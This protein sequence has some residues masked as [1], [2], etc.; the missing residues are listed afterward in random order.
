[1]YVVGALKR[2]TVLNA[3]TWN[4]SRIHSLATSLVNDIQAGIRRYGVTPAKGNP[5]VLMYAY[6]VD[7]LG[8][9]LVDFDDPNIPSLLSIP[10]LGWDGYDP[11]VYAATRARILSRNNSYYFEGTRLDGLGSP[12]THHNYVWPLATAIEACTSDSVP[13]QTQLLGH[14]LHMAASNGL[15][16]ESVHVDDPSKFSRAEFGWANAML[17]V[18]VEQLLGID[19]DRAAEAYRLQVISE[20]ESKERHAMPNKG[21]DI[22]LYY[23]TLEA[24][25]AHV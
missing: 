19:C 11:A 9:S 7:G 23:E 22:P 1:M 2:L 10:L 16:H 15:M 20:R 8:N 18:A 14:L 4:D 12:H 13:R 6:E 24:V 3:Q 21:R 25:V 5:D 17:V